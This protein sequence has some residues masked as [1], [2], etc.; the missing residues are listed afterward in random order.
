MDVLSFFL[1]KF[2]VSC[3]QLGSYLCQ[4]CAQAIEP[5]ITHI[6]PICER[7]AIDGTT[8]PGCTT[9]YTIDGLV[10]A[11]MY[12]GPARALV[13]EL[14]FRYVA[15]IGPI[16]TEELLRGLLNNRSFENEILRDTPAVI[17]IPLHK[18]RK[19]WRGFNQAEMLARLTAERLGYLCDTEV[20][21]RKKYTQQQ[22]RLPLKERRNNLE[23]AFS[24]TSEKQLVGKRVIL[25]DD[26]WT[27]GSTMRS[28]ASVLK[29]A[30]ARSVW[31]LVYAR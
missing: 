5:C 17:P 3:K 12:T 16:I 15:E 7:P 18:R 2:C 8:H 24:V 13:H 4:D 10:S 9:R 21:M 11:V 20:L 27:T 22:A 30:G 14:K 31:G 6:C 19:N 26:V 1:P 28:A 23:D 29:R 25:V